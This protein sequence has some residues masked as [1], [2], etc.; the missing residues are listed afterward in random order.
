[1]NLNDEGIIL[2]K[3]CYGEHSFVLNIFTKEHGLISTLYRYANKNKFIASIGNEVVANFKIKQ[4]H[5]LTFIKLELQQALDIEFF[6]N[7]LLLNILLCSLNLVNETT[8]LYQPEPKIYMQI[9]DFIA[10]IKNSTSPLLELNMLLL[11]YLS[12]SGYRLDYTE[13]AASGSKEE[14]IYL[15]PKT[16]RAVSKQA[17]DP[18]QDKLFTMPQFLQGDHSAS[19]LV[20]MLKVNS[21]FIEKFLYRNRELT[22]PSIFKHYLQQILNHFIL[23]KHNM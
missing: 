21:F 7:S 17:G 12:I 19:S 3:K 13:C 22:K 18:Y 16:G 23:I 20:E 2:S 11:T 6:D 15:S 8:P 10:K 14:L 5:K 9:Q 1:M 4:G